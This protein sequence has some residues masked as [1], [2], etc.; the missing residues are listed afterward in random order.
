VPIRGHIPG[1]PGSL[2]GADVGVAGPL[3]RS[4]ADLALALDVLAG[5]SGLDGAAWRLDLP[6]ARNGGELR[7]LRVATWFE[8]EASPIAADYRLALDGAATA[9]AEAG[10]TVTVADKLPATLGELSELWDR[11][12]MPLMAAGLPAEAFANLAQF[13]DAAP[14]RPLGKDDDTMLWAA[15]VVTQRHR[16]WLVANERR[17]QIRHR[18]AEFFTDHDV[19]LA[20]VAPVPAFPHD[21]NPD[22]LARRLDVD[23]VERPY[24]EALRWAAGIGTLYLPVTVAP[25]G[26]TPAGLPV[27]VQIVAP[28]LHDRT[29]LV[30][31]AHLERLL[32]GF[33]PPS[34]FL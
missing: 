23:G 31:S 16:D 9:L 33:V 6:P 8:D 1:P 22:M 19:L 13:A 21:T 3:G 18:F 27:G 34:S 5:P 7:G 25:I 2:S 15:R 28:H 26:R 29:S 24:M 12:V 30:V 4:T 20:P 10:A 11:L 14:P 32:G 17:H